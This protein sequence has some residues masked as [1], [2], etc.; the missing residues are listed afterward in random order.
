MESAIKNFLKKHNDF[1]CSNYRTL[2]RGLYLHA[3]E[4]EIIV[5][6]EVMNERG[7]NSNRV[8]V[9]E[10]ECGCLAICRT[11]TNA[12]EK[13]LMRIPFTDYAEYTIL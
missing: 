3:D 2:N 5:L 11:E 10:F 6:E 8:F 1:F 4:T 9:F 7:D 13:Y 12:M